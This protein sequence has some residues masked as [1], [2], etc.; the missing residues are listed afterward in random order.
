MF[1]QKKKANILLAIQNHEISQQKE[2]ITTQR[3]EITAHRDH[4]AHIHEEM[5]S[6]I[7]YAR[8]IQQAVFPKTSY[9][10]TILGEHFII[11]KPKDVVSGDFYW[12]TQINDWTIIT[13]DIRIAM[14]RYKTIYELIK[15][16]KIEDGFL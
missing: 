6:S 10:E 1:R 15:T 4:I 8:T 3:D 12:S 16:D 14:R 9:T 2:E 11:F 13:K 5:E 7:V